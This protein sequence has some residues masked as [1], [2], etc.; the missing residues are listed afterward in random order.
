MDKQK[1]NSEK[2]VSVILYFVISIL[3]SL[4]LSNL[5]SEKGLSG[6][7]EN[8]E[9][10]SDNYMRMFHLNGYFFV[11]FPIVFLFFIFLPYL[12][13]GRNF[14]RG[15][16]HGSAKLI[17]PYYANKSISDKEYEKNRILTQNIRLS[18][19]GKNTLPSLNTLV[20]GGMGSGKSY[21]TLIPNILQANT[22]FVITD[23]SKELVKATGNFL[24][25][26]GY[27]IRVLDLEDFTYSV[28]YNFFKYIDS[29]ADIKRITDIIFKST[30]PKEKVSGS[31]DPMW[32]NMAKDY[33]QSLIG[34]IFYMGSEDEKN[35]NTLIWLLNEDHILEQ[36][37][38]ERVPTVVMEMFDELEKRIG[39]NMATDAYHSATDGAVVTIQGVKSSL[40]GRIGAFLIPEVRDLMERDE[41]FLDKV[42]TEKTAL[43]LAVPSEDTSFNFIVNMVYAQL[44]PMLYKK[45]RETIDNKLPIPVQ[46]FI[47]EMANF[48]MPE[49]FPKYLTTGRKHQISYM[50]FFQEIAQIDKMFG[51]EKN[52][53][54]G[55]CSTVLYL[56]GSGYETN[57]YFSEWIGKETVTT[58]NYSR[59]YGRNGN[60]S[61]SHNQGARNVLTPDEIDTKLK[62]NEALLYTQG[63]GFARD[64]KNNPQSHKNYKETSYVN[65]GVYDWTGKNISLFHTYKIKN[66]TG[67]VDYEVKDIQKINI[68][69][70]EKE[71]NFEVFEGE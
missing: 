5:Y 25:K 23:P 63:L 32:D 40:R 8:L 53:V 59:N 9:R 33:L 57:K 24:K 39:P 43:F 10:I 15:I 50:M 70:M 2:I 26:S 41:L 49:D 60:S 3:I 14:R 21:F 64:V 28:K 37:G 7:I 52:T 1:T 12:N 45:A 35:I 46:F 67:K 71:L 65:G 4:L 58:E 11:L 29:D 30:I 13:Y 48:I 66:T 31:Q 20:L 16:E 34:L 55:T 56:R 6:S 18:I 44:F 62:K 19:T 38:G 17:S 61:R 36:K 69:K 51:K 68:D 54:I 42:G 47:D 27:K 22:S